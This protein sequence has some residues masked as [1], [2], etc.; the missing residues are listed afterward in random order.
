M[1][2]GT[3]EVDRL[4]RPF[5]LGDL[6]PAG[7]VVAHEIS[8]RTYNAIYSL[9]LDTVEDAGSEPTERVAGYFER[10]LK[11]RGADAVDFIVEVLRECK[12]LSALKLE[13][14]AESSKIIDQAEQ[15][16]TAAIRL[17]GYRVKSVAAFNLA[18]SVGT[19]FRN[20]QAL[21]AGVRGPQW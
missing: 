17:E 6:A 13:E 5:R 21:V 16:W 10:L 19:A 14:S 8:T 2:A 9:L 1:T 20:L 11:R 4:M 3:P 7:T 12:M 15:L 18:D